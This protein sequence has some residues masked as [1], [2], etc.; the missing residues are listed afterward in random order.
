M[1]R[2]TT[3]TNKHDFT[4]QIHSTVRTNTRFANMNNH[5]EK[6]A[7]ENKNVVCKDCRGFDNGCSEYI[8]KYHLPCSEFQWW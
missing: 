3:K 7:K 5:N 4:K 6:S 1:A 2:K 8:G